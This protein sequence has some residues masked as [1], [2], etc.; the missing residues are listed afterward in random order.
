MSKKK[1]EKKNFFFFP[2]ETDH[3]K[4]LSSQLSETDLIISTSILL[5]SL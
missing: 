4:D 1:K 3:K 2:I 5:I